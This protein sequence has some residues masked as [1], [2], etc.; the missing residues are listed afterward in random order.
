MPNPAKTLRFPM[1]LLLAGLTGCLIM[2]ATKSTSR[3]L[4]LT[5]SNVVEGPPLALVLAAQATSASVGL[6]ATMKRECQRQ[7]LAVTEVTT[8]KHARTGGASDPRGKVFGL[9][10][11]PLTVPI[12]AMI[13]GVVVAAHGDETTKHTKLVGTKRFECTTVAAKVPVQLTLASGITVERT[14]DG[15]GQLAFLIP[16]TEPYSGTVTISAD[17]AQPTQIKYQRPMPSVTAVREAIMTCAARHAVRGTMKLQLTVSTAGAPVRI[18]VDA[19]DGAFA[20]CVNTAIVPLRFPEAQRGV[21]L[22]LPF[23]LAAF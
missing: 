23:Q 19:G 13:T 18:G 15:D 12:S 11:A 7:V 8:S 3:S 14:T 6:R 17:K 4:G 5:E 22:V 2:P 1:L 10:L 16:M 21:M 20:A 9:L